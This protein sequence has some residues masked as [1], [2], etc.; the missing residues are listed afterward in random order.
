MKSK[1]LTSKA[2][3]NNKVY[4][5]PQTKLIMCFVICVVETKFQLER[6]STS[7]PMIMGAFND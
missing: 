7:N 1:I 3:H 2:L 4:H 6:I 5:F